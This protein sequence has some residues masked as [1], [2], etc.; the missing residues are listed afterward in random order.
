MTAEQILMQRIGALTFEAAQ[1]QAQRD[2][3]AAENAELRKR[4]GED[5]SA[6]SSPQGDPD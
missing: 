3:L 2:Q 1:L 6:E 4:L 5:E